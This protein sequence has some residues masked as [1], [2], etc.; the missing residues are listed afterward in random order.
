MTTSS[1]YNSS[2]SS[3]TTYYEILQLSP[4]AS[5]LEIKKAYRR[6]ALQYHPDRNSD[7][8]AKELFQQVGQAYACLSDP[9]QRREYDREL[10]QQQYQQHHVPADSTYTL[11]PS[12]APRYKHYHQPWGPN[13]VV[14]D[15]WTQF[16]FL[17]HNDPF[18][19]DYFENPEKVQQ[20]WDDLQHAATSTTR[21]NTSSSKNNRRGRSGNSGNP[22][23]P[24]SSSRVQQEGWIPWLLRQCGIQ[25]TM[26]TIVQDENGRIH[27][28]QISSV[29]SRTKAPQP[30]QQQHHPSPRQSASLSSAAGAGPK[31]TTTIQQETVSYIENGQRV[32]IKK[33]QVQGTLIEDKI[34]GSSLVERKINGVSVPIQNLQ[35]K[36]QHLKS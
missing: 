28:K 33:R 22:S 20:E 32:W 30:Y 27:A 13:P 24:S 8:N 3:S 10:Q 23:S 1:F 17:F 15:P 34:V 9:I 36:E 5:P 16:D 2:S 6:L 21:G 12:S 19:R 18:F 7:P 29:P 4:T 25:F 11:S 26:T 31:A 35:Q 14:I